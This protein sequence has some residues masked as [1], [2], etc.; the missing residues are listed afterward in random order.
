MTPASRRSTARSI[1]EPILLRCYITFNVYRTET[2]RAERRAPLPIHGR[3][4]GMGQSGGLTWAEVSPP[5]HTGQLSAG[6][7]RLAA[8]WAPGGQGW[9]SAPGPSGT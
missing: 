6:A 5:P 2:G 7:A 4:T 1:T 3:R 9:S 8:H